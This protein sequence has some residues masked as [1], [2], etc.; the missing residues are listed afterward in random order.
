M[1]SNEFFQRTLVLI[2]AVLLLVGCSGAPA[3]PAATPTPACEVTCTYN[4]LNEDLRISITCESG[5][6]MQSAN[7][8][9]EGSKEHII[10]Q[11]SYE[12]SGNNYNIA[13]IL[14]PEGGKWNVTVEV[15]GGVF[16]ET[17]QTCE[18]SD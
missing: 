16:G 8:F 15:T 12:T 3:E 18:C 13:A 9:F 17:T 11:R 7:S 2:L 6:A 10:G 1:N 14:W 5:P 4:A